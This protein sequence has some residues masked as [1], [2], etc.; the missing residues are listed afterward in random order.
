MSTMAPSARKPR[1]AKPPAPIVFTPHV[2]VI[3]HTDTQIPYVDGAE[4]TLRGTLAQDWAALAARFP[5]VTLKRRFRQT[6]DKEFTALFTRAQ[7]R[8]P[9]F[10][11]PVFTT[12]FTLVIGAD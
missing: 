6:S 9:S 1:A 7:K 8:D 5:G 10:V 4:R 3:F 11:P 12:D 2:R